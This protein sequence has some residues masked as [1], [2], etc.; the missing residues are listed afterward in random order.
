ML[1]VQ[2]G[3]FSQRP[4]PRCMNIKHKTLL[5]SCVMENSFYCTKLHRLQWRKTQLYMVCPNS[6]AIVRAGWNASWEVL[7]GKYSFFVCFVT[8]GGLFVCLFEIISAF[9]RP[10]T[11]FS[12]HTL[13]QQCSSSYRAAWGLHTFVKCYHLCPWHRGNVREWGAIEAFC[14]P[15]TEVARYGSCKSTHRDCSNLNWPLSIWEAEE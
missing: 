7:P 14:A 9:Y 12:L 4:T 13:L 6:D 2:T 15:E 8:R 10:V 5:H 1:H 3:C 11:H